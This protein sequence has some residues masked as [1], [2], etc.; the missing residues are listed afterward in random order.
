MG[1]LVLADD[2]ISEVPSLENAV[3]G[4]IAYQGE[5]LCGHLQHAKT[6]RVGIP[7][8]ATLAWVSLIS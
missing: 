3:T 6:A 7:G 2:P 4:P 8:Y 5:E 1:F